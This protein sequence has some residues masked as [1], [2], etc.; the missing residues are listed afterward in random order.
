M[1]TFVVFQLVLDKLKVLSVNQLEQMKRGPEL[2]LTIEAL[3]SLNSL[4]REPAE[5]CV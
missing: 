1:N 3:Q 5:T 4:N 2:S